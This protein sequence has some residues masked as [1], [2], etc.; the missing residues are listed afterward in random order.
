MVHC[1]WNL[2]VTIKSG[3][4]FKCLFLGRF[5]QRIQSVGLGRLYGLHTLTY[6]M[7]Y[8]GLIASIMIKLLKTVPLAT[9]IVCL[10]GKCL[11]AGFLQSS[12]N[13]SWKNLVPSWK[14][15]L[16]PFRLPYSRTLVLLGR[17]ILHVLPWQ[18]N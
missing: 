15:C 11:D 10:S 12:S 9:C 17:W 13:S 6:W 8:S 2:P 5:T 1:C 14:P 4:I 7:P 3:W 16:F 18:T